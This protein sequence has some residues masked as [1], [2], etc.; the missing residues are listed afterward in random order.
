MDGNTDMVEVI[1]MGIAANINM[2]HGAYFLQTS[3]EEQQY[4]KTKTTILDST[5]L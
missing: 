5:K 4:I 3:S 1:P 2:S